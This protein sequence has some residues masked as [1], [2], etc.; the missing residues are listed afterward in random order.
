MQLITKFYPFTVYDYTSN[1]KP[2][3][4]WIPIL[5]FITNQILK[6][7]LNTKSINLLT[8]APLRLRVTIS[9]ADRGN[10]PHKDSK[11]ALVDILRR[12]GVNSVRHLR[13]LP[14]NDMVIASMFSVKM[15]VNCRQ[16]VMSVNVNLSILVVTIDYYHLYF[17]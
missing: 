3:S 9:T 4:L 12:D 2:K 8:T 17:T 11:G 5:V 13:F 6:L 15:Y 10:I 16:I 7:Q 14:S 1:T